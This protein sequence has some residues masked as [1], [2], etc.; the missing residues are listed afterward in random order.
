MYA[1]VRLITSP[2]ERQAVTTHTLLH[3]RLN[4]SQYN[5]TENSICVDSLC[6]ILCVLIIRKSRKLNSYLG[7]EYLSSCIYISLSKKVKICEK[8]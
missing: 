4:I 1:L 7:R 3:P 5:E 6:L 8:Y 2:Y